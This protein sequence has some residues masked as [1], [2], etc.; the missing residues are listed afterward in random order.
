MITGTI[1]RDYDGNGVRDGSEPGVGGTTITAY[2][3]D[4]VAIGTT[5]S[6]GD[7]ATL[8]QYTLSVSVAAGRIRVE[9]TPPAPFRTAVWGTSSD[10]TVQFLDVGAAAD[11]GVQ[12][13]GDICNNPRIVTS[14]FIPGDNSQSTQPTVKS[15]DYL[16]NGRTGEFAETDLAYANEVG[17]VYGIAFQSSTQT[18]FTS[19]YVRRGTGQG[20]SN[21]T[22]TI[23]RMGTGGGASVFIELN[24]LAGIDTGANPHP[25]GSN[26][27]WV[28]DAGGFVAAGK[29]GIGDLDISAD[30]TTLYAMNLFQRELIVMPLGVAGGAPTAPAA[31]S[32]IRR[33]VPTPANCPAADVR[34]FALKYYNNS[35]YVGMICSG[36]S[37]LAQVFATNPTPALA[38]IQAARSLLRAYVYR[39]D[40]NANAFDGAPMLEF[41]LTYSRGAINFFFTG[42]NPDN[43]GEW[44]PWTDVWLPSYAPYSA[45]QANPNIGNPQPVLT[46]IEFDGNNFMVLG[47][48]DRFGDQGFS[49]YDI[50][51]AGGT[52]GYD[53]YQAG[54]LILACQD[55]GG[56]WQVENNGQC[57]G[58]G[59]SGGAGNNQGPGGGEFFFN[60]SFEP[61]HDEITIG[62]L[63]VLP[64]SREVVSTVFDA[65]DTF[66]NGTRTYNLDTAAISRRI[67]LFPPGTLLGKGAGLGDIEFICDAGPIE[68]GNRVWRDDDLDGVQDPGEP[69][70]AGVTVQLF[71]PDGTLLGTAITDVDGEYY[72]SSAPGT[73]ALNAIYGITGLTFNTS[74]FEVR[75][76]VTQPALTDLYL[77]TPNADG[78]TNGD[79]RDS[80]GILNGIIA[81]ARFDT[82]GPGDNNHTYDFGFNNSV[83]QVTV[84]PT[85]P[86]TPPPGVT[87]TPVPGIPGTPVPGGTPASEPGGPTLVKLVDR[88]FALPGDT[89]T[90]TIVV[91]NPNPFDLTNITVTDNVPGELIIL[92]ATSSAGTVSVSGQNVT[93]T[94]ATLPAN[95]SV[96]ITLTTRIRDGVVGVAIENVALLGGLRASATTVVI[97]GLPRTGETPWWRL[98]LLLGVGAAAVGGYAASRRRRVTEL[99]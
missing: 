30:E 29:M 17:T 63:G 10:T 74:G 40:V 12:A 93:L 52:T 33:P 83:V 3:D 23:Y 56:A 92:N 86:G 27:P 4:G 91:G 90:W 54:D 31:G 16:A 25:N 94:L 59:P 75:I 51:P 35:L 1:F 47:F 36:E 11:F 5:Q 80:D 58:R 20:S 46:D 2:N 72:F 39:Y 22:G 60:E 34:P 28:Q 14:C 43:D 21:N 77:T 37:E 88:P 61:Y 76:D 24:G 41:P 97:T 38:D 49:Q 69:P 26:P 7:A 62:G 8:G 65:W 18:L 64:G 95:S 82:G 99:S 44:L 48:R 70:L 78:S 84:P 53:A 68:I 96:T 85:T 81:V 42:I 89:V 67:Q 50:S 13:P 9:Y 66:E 87:V 15:W 57:L 19:S 73:N 32:I 98:P 71:A 79:S 6:S 45:A 55:G